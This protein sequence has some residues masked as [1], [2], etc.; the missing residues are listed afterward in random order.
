MRG[1]EHPA[2]H[3][4]HREPG[5]SA[6]DKRLRAELAADVCL[7]NVDYGGQDG[8]TMQRSLRLFLDEVLPHVREP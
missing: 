3:G 7:W 4:G 1:H 8:E 2:V 6:D 5:Q